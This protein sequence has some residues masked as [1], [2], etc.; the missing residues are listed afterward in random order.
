LRIQS[1]CRRLDPSWI[2]KYLILARPIYLPMEKYL[3]ED[4]AKL[5]DSHWWH[6]SKRNSVIELI[7]LIGRKNLR[8]LDIGCGTGGNLKA[9]SRYGEVWGIDNAAEAI[10]YCKSKGLKN[11][12]LGSSDKTGFDGATFDAV[13]LLDVLEHVEE[14]KTLK[15]IKRILKADG[16]LIITVPAFSWLWSRW[17]EVLHHKR[18]YTSSG[19][20]DLLAKSGFDVQKISYMYSF[21][22]LPAYLVRFIKSKVS[23]KKYSSDFE[24]SSPLLNKI[25]LTTSRLE[26]FFW[27]TFGLPLG[28]SLICVAKK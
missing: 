4:L 24:L 6:I 14:A 5:E 12:K 26:R 15:E 20:A 1:R 27:M 7:K 23:G 25:F 18:R 19:L 22:V 8:I 2:N 17:D 16:K 3:Y 9:F 10:N 13:T 28:T 11:V 21:L